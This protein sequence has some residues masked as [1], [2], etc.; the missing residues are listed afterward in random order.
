[1]RIGILTFHFAINYGAVIQAWALKESLNRLGHETFV[2]DY[3]PKRRRLPWYIYAVRKS[4]FDARLEFLFHKFVK[5]NL[6]FA[7]D[8]TLRINGRKEKDGWGA[9]V[10]GSDQVWN[11]KYFT[12]KDGGHNRH[13]FLDGICDDAVKIAYA[14]SIGD[15]EWGRFKDAE[16]MVAAI[17]RFDGIGVRE[18]VAQDELRK[19]GVDSTVVADPTLLMDK[20]GYECFTCNRGESPTLTDYVFGYSLSEPETCAEVLVRCSNALNATPRFCSIYGE[21]ADK[22]RTLYPALENDVVAPSPDEWVRMVSE[23][24]FIVTDSFHGTMMALLF[25]RPFCVVLKPDRDRMNA[26]ITEILD[27]CGLSDRIVRTGTDVEAIAAAPIAWNAVDLHVSGL[28]TS[29][30]EFLRGI[31]L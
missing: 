8:S 29:S 11:R 2:I 5:K 28:R 20:S 21:F 12:E 25:H 16:K 31:L 27:V 17:K 14:A 15:G 19:F 1:M 3:N 4:L 26:R 6:P 22:C 23:A 30:L 9:I 10:V 24:T 7:P 18:R 13:Y